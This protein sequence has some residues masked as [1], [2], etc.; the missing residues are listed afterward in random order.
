MVSIYVHLPSTLAVL[1]LFFQVARLMLC[2]LSRCSFSVIVRDDLYD[3][4]YA[5]NAIHLVIRQRRREIAHVMNSHMVTDT[6]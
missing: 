4:F 5:H 6:G 2:P 3:S 1:Y